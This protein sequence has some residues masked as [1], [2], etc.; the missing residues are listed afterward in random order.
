MRDCRAVM[1]QRWLVP[2][3]STMQHLRPEYRS[4]NHLSTL[5]ALI[6]ED[7]LRMSILKT[8]RQLSLPDCWVGAGF[9]RDAVWDHLHGGAVRPPQGDIDVI[10]F[11][12]GRVDKQHER[13]IETQLAACDGRW[14]WSVKNQAR[15]H[16]ANGD[17]PYRS[18]ADAIRHWPDTAT[19]VALR[20]NG[21]DDIEVIAPYRLDDLFA[22]VLRPTPRFLEEKRPI[23]EERISSK[24]WRERWPR[25][26]FHA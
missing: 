15:M 19:A 16:H 25:L 8:V 2:M 5:K 6:L 21:Q 1:V 12:A 9:V 17:A 22:G 20:C 23:Y 4:V 3:R 18:C 26:I 24:G 10:W 13:A 11:D 7:P 14:P